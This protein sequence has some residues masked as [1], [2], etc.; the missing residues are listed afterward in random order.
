MIINYSNI[1]IQA[2]CAIERT[3]SVVITLIAFLML[4]CFIS[5]NSA[6]ANT[7]YT[8]TTAGGNW[9]SAATW[10]GGIVPPSGL[11]SDIS[12]DG[13]VYADV[14][15][16]CSALTINPSVSSTDGLYIN[17]GITLTVD[18][19]ITLNG[20]NKNGGILYVNGGTCITN[21]ALLATNT[22]PGANAEIRVTTGLLNFTRASAWTLPGQSK[23]SIA[24]NVIGSGSVIFSGALTT[25]QY[26]SFLISGTNG[27]INFN[28]TFD[29][30]TATTLSVTAN[31]QYTF[32]GLVTQTSGVISNTGVAGVFNFNGGYTTNQGLSG[33]AT[34]GGTYVYFGTS[35]ICTASAMTLDPS[36]T[37]VFSANTT[38][39]PTIAITFG[40]IQINSGITATFAAGTVNVAGNWLNNGGTF[41][42]GTNA[43]TFNGTGTQTITN[44]TGEI[45][46]NLIV[47]STGPFTLASSTDVIVSNQLTMTSGNLNLNGRTLSL[48]SSANAGVSTLV[49]TTG[50]MYGGTYRRWI[51]AATS[52][53]STVAPLYGLFPIGT[54]TQYRPVEINSTGN[55]TTGG[56]LAAI[57]TNAATVTDVIYNDN[58]AVT[59]Q[60]IS[61]MKSTLSTPTVGTTLTGGTYTIF[62][63]FN[64]L[65]T[66]T[67]GNLRL[68]TLAGAPKG[69]GTHVATAGTDPSAPIL[70]RSGL[71][72]A[73]LANDFV[74]GTT[75]KTNTSIRRFLYS[76]T[77]GGTSNWSLASTWSLISGGAGASG[78][79]PPVA[80]DYV[81]ISSGQTVTVD[82]NFSSAA[83][84]DVQT[85][86][87]L[88]GGFILTVGNDLTTAGTGRI[89]PS[90]A[91]GI[92]GNLTTAGTG[93]SSISALFIVGGNLTIGSGTTFT[94][95]GGVGL[96]VSGNLQ[97]NGT[98]ALGTSSMSLSGAAGSTISGT[99]SITGS[100][101]T[102]INVTVA[103]KTI[104]SG[105]SLTLGVAGTAPTFKIT[106]SIT[107]T[108]NGTMTLLGPL[109]GSA[110]GSTWINASGSV[111]NL[112]NTA[113][114]F[115]T[116][117]T[118][119]ASA[120][121][122][123]VN[124]NSTGAQTIYVT[125]YDN[126]SCSN[127]NTKTVNGATTV[128]GTLLIQDATTVTSASIT[129]AITGSGGLTMTGTSTY[130]LTRGNGNN[131]YPELTGS[132]SLTGG[133][134][135]INQTFSA[136]TASIKGVTYYNL[137]VIGQKLDLSQLTTV[138]N[139]F[140]YSGT[141]SSALTVNLTVGGLT[142]ING[143][144]GTLNLNSA[145][146][147]TGS[148]T[149]NNAT[150]TLLNSNASSSTITV[151]TGDWTNTAG[152]ATM[153]N[154]TT[155]FTGTGAQNIAGV[156][157]SFTNLT[158]NNSSSA[159]VTL[160]ASA[161][162]TVSTLLTM[163][164]TSGTFNTGSLASALIGAGGITASGGDLQFGEVTGSLLPRLTG[165]N[166][167]TGGTI[168]YN[169]NGNQSVIRGI[170]STSRTLANYF[171]IV[172]SGTNVG[173]GCTKTLDQDI[174][175]N[176]NFTI[177]GDA[178]VD[179][180]TN[181]AISIK[182]NYN[183]SSAAGDPFV[184]RSGTVTFS[185]T[186]N[187][188]ISNTN[189][190]GSTFYNII[191]NNT[192]SSNT[193]TVSSTLGVTANGV[194][195][196]TSGQVITTSTQLLIFGNTATISPALA[197]GTNTSFVSGPVLKKMS[198]SG[199][200]F[201]FPVGK[202]NVY[203]PMAI[204]TSNVTVESWT[205]EY[206]SASAPNAHNVFDATV[207]QI[208]DAEYWNLTR[209]ATGG[210]ATVQL[211]WDVNSFVTNTATLLVVHWD[212]TKWTTDCGGGCTN[213]NSGA[214]GTPPG[215]AKSVSIGDA[216]FG[217]AGTT[218]TF[219]F[220]SSLATDNPLGIDRYLVANG[221]WGATSSWAACSGCG[222]GASV[223]NATNNVFLENGRTLTMVAG[224]GNVS[225]LKLTIGTST[226]FGAGAGTLAFAALTPTVTV[227]TGGIVVA[228]NGN[229][230]GSAAA[231]LATTGNFTLNSDISAG[232]FSVQL[233]TTGGQTITG[234]GSVK[235]LTIN[236]ST[237][238]NG[239]LTVTNLLAGTNT[240]TNGATGVLRYNGAASPTITG[241]NCATLG[242]TVEFNG[243][244]G[245][246]DV[247]LKTQT[248]YNLLLNYSGTTKRASNA[249]VV[250][251]YFNI[252]NGVT[253]DHGAFNQSITVGGDITING[254][255]S[256]SASAAFILNGSAAQNFFIYYP[257]L[258]PFYNLTLSNS[259]AAG[260]VLSSALNIANG[261]TLTFT[262]GYLTLGAYDLT[263]K[264]TANSIVG[265]SSTSFIVTNSGSSASG[266][267]IMQGVTAA[268]VFPVGSSSAAADYTPVTITCT[269][270]GPQD[271]T[272]N[273]CNNIYNDGNCSGGTQL[274]ASV[275]NK[276]WNVS[277]TGGTSTM[278]L[279]WNASNEATGFIRSACYIDHYTAGSWQ[280]Q[281][282]TD[283]T[284]P[285]SGT[286][287]YSRTVAGVTSFSPQG[288]ASSGALPIELLFFNA[289]L[290]GKNAELFWETGSEVNNEHFTLQKSKNTELVESFAKINGAGNSS[291]ALFYKA[292]DT[293]PYEGLS[294]Y[295]LKQTDFD[296]KFT[297]SNWVAVDNKAKRNFDFKIF[298]NPSNGEEIYISSETLGEGN[299]EVLVVLYN[300]MGEIVFSKVIV[301][302]NGTFI[303]AIDPSKHLGPGVY[304]VVGTSNN[305]FYRQK[306]VIRE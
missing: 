85:G 35:F 83:Y 20:S 277:G 24:M 177:S 168:T 175:V 112:G 204:T 56:Y 74:A 304:I 297:F 205:G 151:T 208:S 239:D 233:N 287:P 170:G 280:R 12:I 296:G 245:A 96:S 252:G 10:V 27:S 249:I 130:D 140:T 89:T 122:N 162:T 191:I 15:V 224:D 222:A 29:L 121:G 185:G 52:I 178:V 261:G 203:H 156:G 88:T 25:N 214:P 41:T 34:M 172:F 30:N 220:G 69:V 288:V 110:G 148:L 166:T 230:T 279:Q 55:A 47:N 61:D 4:Y 72:A 97:V 209:S 105:T 225:C 141:A 163:T 266:R 167:I 207:K 137:I 243:P 146:L 93:S 273:V 113:N 16:T 276:T 159:T 109:D 236:A 262:T 106:G 254:N 255:Y 281:P 94:M 135:S 256:Y 305:D 231:V 82:V 301:S 174:L 184:E 196:F 95:N 187:Q 221:N 169:G 250:N 67:S 195:T 91:W 242:N 73:N 180:G 144:G 23:I 179:V 13:S 31:G 75:D 295:R 217:A 234:T 265:A 290:V 101:A 303:S 211:N 127:G 37:T 92:T 267:L 134:V 58:Q 237:T 118:L 271:Y 18:S 210:A 104:S 136:K 125:T 126:L 153:T 206:F 103:S 40:N 283:L 212:G 274:T 63:T 282:A 294:Y 87:T 78:A 229:I 289:K 227:G 238:N 26:F 6:S 263:L 123:T 226:G 270:G 147:T 194:V 9:S 215:T 181:R 32:N 50:T 38:V 98:L 199:T 164:S 213:T 21:S 114:V 190:N 299:S 65:G 145:D 154:I 115:A 188:T 198:A 44:T 292:V 120:G 80:G 119:T 251:G 269:A 302:D 48:G 36:S 186:S 216:V 235:N 264:G 291:Q 99:G 7:T 1:K 90:A 155:I 253:F 161:S 139:N 28:S 218:T 232:S 86:A 116:S 60:R 259:S 192:P 158:I 81:T 293:S 111:L 300:I 171:N 54:S 42:P 79:G 84:I 39:T 248:F 19:N 62:V 241:L 173:A 298:P 5:T 68:E 33:F 131:T 200:T 8:S 107:V 124:Y 129:N 202:A 157:T 3:F 102:G 306:L 223:P 59:I 183:C 152:T 201:V 51:P 76:T 193:I 272:I 246:F 143:A 189:L 43:V 77:A 2:C 257:N 53:S 149:L 268:R 11:T 150:A 45:F 219:V 22:P 108:N 49:R 128:N 228:S 71:T 176:G 138:T 275:V 117:G 284:A 240:L 46:Y 100:S 133:T 64:S 14:N 160:T 66:G 258:E 70:K 285:A 142:L 260:V 286:G 247:S 57:H 165:T 182:G 17:T 244:S 132:Y 278:K 197:M